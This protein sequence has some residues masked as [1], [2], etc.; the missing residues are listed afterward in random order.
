MDRLLYAHSPVT[1]TDLPNLSV[2][3]V[4]HEFHVSGGILKKSGVAG[5]IER[6]SLRPYPGWTTKQERKK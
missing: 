4:T 1:V 3:R 6:C 2:G 5:N